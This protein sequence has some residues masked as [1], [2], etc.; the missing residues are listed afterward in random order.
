MEKNPTKKQVLISNHMYLLSAN[1]ATCFS[2]LSLIYW[3]EGM[4][5]LIFSLSQFF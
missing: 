5:F 3:V 4:I 2:E 1:L